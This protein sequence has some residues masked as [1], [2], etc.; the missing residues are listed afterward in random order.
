MSTTTVKNHVKRRAFIVVRT[1]SFVLANKNSPS[2]IFVAD[3]LQPAKIALFASG[4]LK[5]SCSYFK[6]P[7]SSPNSY[8]EDDKNGKYVKGD[9]KMRF[10]NS[11]VVIS[12]RFEI[13]RF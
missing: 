3:L 12:T 8:F 2:L 10:K 7:S 13:G 5:T 9:I 4:L 6:N 1:R 11:F